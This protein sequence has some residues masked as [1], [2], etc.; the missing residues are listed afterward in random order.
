DLN[1]RVFV[2]DHSAVPDADEW[3]VLPFI[4]SDD[5]GQGVFASSVDVPMPPA[6]FEALMELPGWP[7]I[8]CLANNTTDTRFVRRES[9]VLSR[10]E[11]TQ[12]LTRVLSRRLA[13][14]AGRAGLP[15]FTAVT[16]GGWSHPADLAWVD[17]LAFSVDPTPLASALSDACG[18]RVRAV[19]PGRRITLQA[20]EV[21]EDS[22]PA[23]ELKGP[24]ERPDPGAVEVPAMPTRAVDSAAV[25][26]ARLEAEL[27]PFARFLFARGIFAQ[28][29]SLPRSDALAFAVHTESSPVVLAYRS[30]AGGFERVTVADPFT[31]FLS[32]FE[33]W[34]ADLLALLEGR[35]AASALCYTGRLRCWNRSPQRLRVSPQLLWLFSHP[36]HRPELA[37]GLYEHVAASCGPVEIA[38]RAR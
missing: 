38:V 22:D 4:V 1:L 11:D 37:R 3:D 30:A 9:G 13:A 10:S 15:R 12:A 21:V 5:A 25:D 27:Q 26:E 7:G 28:V 29:H 14:F 36:L 33:C 6:M 18:G 24:I 19:L 20:L 8:L 34:A 35:L 17:A 2:A 32:G 23:V 16:G 31:H